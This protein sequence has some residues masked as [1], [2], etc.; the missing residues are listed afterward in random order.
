VIRREQLVAAIRRMDASERELLW[1][2]LR[3]RVPDTAIAR[4]YGDGPTDVARRRAAAIERMA[5]DLGVQRGEDFGSVLTGL[6][7]AETWDPIASEL[8]VPT[9]TKEQPPG[10]AR[11]GPPPL[12]PEPPSTPPPSA[13]SRTRARVRRMPYPLLLALAGAIVVGVVVTAVVLASQGGGEHHRGGAS[14]VP[15]PEPRPGRPT[16]GGPCYFTAA[17]AGATQLYSRPGGP[18]LARI[19]A[20]TPWGSP[21]VLHVVVRRA[22]WLGVVAPQLP[23][24]ELGWLPAHAA[25][26]GCVTW[27]LDADLSRRLLEVRR[28]GRVVRAVRFGVE[29]RGLTPTGRFGVTDRLEVSGRSPYGCCVLALSGHQSPGSTSG[30]RLAVYK[31]PGHP[32]AGASLGAAALRTSSDDARWLID[33]IPLGTPVFIQR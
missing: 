31:G 6:M 14:F 27:S 25:R 23:N 4:L 12:V 22:A 11:G 1:L 7:E 24:G 18:A 19:A 3:R 17:V 33:N 28:G 9:P 26:V 29:A 16:S 30:A 21:V 13:F 2:S 20:R 5:D 8:S 32:P 10:P 15:R